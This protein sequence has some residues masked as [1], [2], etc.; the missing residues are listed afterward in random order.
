MTERERQVERTVE[1]L[2]ERLL[3]DKAVA[4]ACR[5]PAPHGQGSSFRERWAAQVDAAL[6]ITAP[7]PS[8]SQGDQER[9]E[10]SERVCVR[11]PEG[12][13]IWRDCPGCPDCNPAPTHEDEG[14]GC[15]RCG[16]VVEGPT[17]HDWYLTSPRPDDGLPEAFCPKCADEKV[18]PE[19][20]DGEG[21]PERVVLVRDVCDAPPRP[22]SILSAEGRSHVEDRLAHFPDEYETRRYISATSQDSSGLEDTDDV[23]L[24]GHVRHEHHTHDGSNYGAC[25]YCSC[26]SFTLE[27]PRAVETAENAGQ[28]ALMVGQDR[29]NKAEAE[30]DKEQRRRVEAKAACPKASSTEPAEEGQGG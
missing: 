13:Y 23:C 3:S 1:R 24:C 25:A 17:P 16:L 26:E 4:A 15:D 14:I 6:A 8:D 18:Q 21:W 27:R 19:G 2:R 11:G 30:R 7:P 10:G 9:C 22:L 28:R 5:A 20:G 12:E 29:A